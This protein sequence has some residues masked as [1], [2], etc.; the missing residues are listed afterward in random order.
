MLSQPA[1]FQSVCAAVKYEEHDS[2]TA[3]KTRI[4]SHPYCRH[5]YIFFPQMAICK[6]VLGISALDVFFSPPIKI[7]TTD[8]VESAA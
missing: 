5:V 6:I 3:Y 7:G 4:Y 1:C 2:H 8:E